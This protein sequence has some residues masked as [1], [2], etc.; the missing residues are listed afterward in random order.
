MLALHACRAYTHVEVKRCLW[1]HVFA[2][3]QSGGIMQGESCRGCVFATAGLCRAPDTCADCRIHPPR[4]AV[5]PDQDPWA[6]EA[7]PPKVGNPP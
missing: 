2:S 6:A 5:L 7:S 1:P 4:A 3:L